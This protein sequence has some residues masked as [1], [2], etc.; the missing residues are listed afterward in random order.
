MGGEGDGRASGGAAGWVRWLVSGA[1]ARPG[2]VLVVWVALA[3]AAT[4]GVLRLGFETTPS[5][6]LDTLSPPW[7]FYQS[8]LDR[9]GGDEI[10]VVALE[11]E[12]PWDP[13]AL[14]D[15]VRITRRLER[16]PEVRRVDS[17]ATVPIV[18]ARPDGTLDLAPALPGGEEVGPAAARAAREA[19]RGDR[20]VPDSLVSADGRTLAVNVL[21]EAD[22]DDPGAV[23]EAAYAALADL[24]GGRGWVSG[25]PVYEHRVGIA[26][27]RELLTFVPAT[28]ALIALLLLAVFRAPVAL[29]A[30]AASSGIGT[31]I[32]LGVMGTLGEPITMTGMVLPSVLLALGSA[33]VMHVLVAARGRREPAELARAVADVAPPIALSGLTTAVGFFAIMTIRIDAIRALGAYGGLGVLVVL[34]ASLTLAPALLRWR[35]LPASG[36][37]LDRWLRE[38]GVPRLMD[39]VDRRRRHVIATWVVLLAATAVGLVRLH[40]ETDAVRWW[41]PGSEMRNHYDAIRDRLSGIS[42]MNVVID[43][44]DGGRVI[45]PEVLSRVDALQQHLAAHPD[46]GKAVSIA[47]PLRQMHGGF[48]DD[49]SQPL[50]AGEDLVAQYL[51]LLES[52]EP[53]HDAITRDR[54]SANVLLRLDDNG[55]RRL[56][57]VAH[58]AE[59]WWEVHGA[60]GFQARATG[61]MYEFARSEEAIAWGQIRGLSV[62][63]LAIGAIL[64]L[65]FRIPSVAAIALVPNLAALG[66]IYGVMGWA[67]VPLDGGTVCM[68]SLA[69]GIA[70]DDTIHVVAGFRDRRRA[71]AAARAA[72]ADTF[73]RV[74]PALV[75]TT[76]TIAAGFAVLGLSEFL[77]TRNLGLVTTFVVVICL[78][79]DTTLLP[80]VLLAER[81]TF[82]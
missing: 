82:R 71:G 46:V 23:V 8:S 58:A 79:A 66:M 20:L 31:W 77:L 64:L 40:V 10:V 67:D 38:R 73:E 6:F 11:G 32:V 37:G 27:R 7:A 69:L 26:T 61:I 21:L 18:R 1:V 75:Y 19:V 22:V 15:V 50:P 60:E 81:P 68:G 12:G 80:S 51:L 34:A 52:V 63:L 5:S 30:P 48:D 3:A 35:P 62:A 78:V 24:R 59:S 49:P 16:L 4:P 47:D 13:A 44:R 45:A 33:Y 53:V 56:L 36:A 2:L 25:V 28:L 72:L 43:S 17:L 41:P 54:R 70:V 74:L 9:F 65:L 14:S 29:A 55:S 39:L 42:P 57:D 76:V